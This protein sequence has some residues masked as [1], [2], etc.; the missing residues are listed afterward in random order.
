MSKPSADTNLEL[1]QLAVERK[2]VSAAQTA[3]FKRLDALSCDGP[4]TAFFAGAGGCGM[5]GL[6]T[7]MLECGWK[8]WGADSNGFADNDPLIAAGLIPVAGGQSPPPVSLVA[9]SVAVPVTDRQFSEARK[10]AGQ[11][12]VYSELLGEI[13]R[14]R[15]CL[16]VAGSHGKTT[17]TA[18]IAFGMRLANRQPGFLVGGNVPQLGCSADWGSHDEPLVGESCEYDR[19]F[20]QLSPRWVALCNVDAEH[21]DTYPGGYPEVEAAFR[22]FLGKLPVGGAVFAG[23]EAPDL[24]AAT[25]ADWRKLPAL[26]SKV[27]VGLAG[28]HNR[29]NAAVVAGVLR[30]FDVPEEIVLRALVEYRGATRRMEQVGEFKQAQVISDYAHHP[31]EV[32]AT[33]Q[34]AQERWPQRR[35]VVVFQPHQARRFE[36]F[37]AEFVEALSLADALVLLPIYR[38]RDPEDLQPVTSELLKPLRVQR[39]RPIVAVEGM[40]QA[41]CYL[42]NEIKKNDLLLCLGAGDIDKFA[43][44]LSR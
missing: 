32:A 21:P 7:F 27:K 13:T 5:R 19:T 2:T 44:S 12:F 42:D 18:W 35:L 25:K 9:R 3:H 40:E 31:T 4:K 11:Q 8:V 33:L 22:E 43:R 36:R 1:A 34:A 37:R 16:A 41:R 29:L 26:D 20:H 23:P 28:K 24:S 10:S 15:P 6:A 38:A 17:I 14:L 30:S 39:E